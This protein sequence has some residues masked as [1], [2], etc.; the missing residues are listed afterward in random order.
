MATDFFEPFYTEE[1]AMKT[2]VL[3]VT[4]GL[5]LAGSL[6]GQVASVSAD[7]GFTLE[8]RE[9]GHCKLINVDYGR[10]LFNGSCTIEQ[11]TSGSSTI[12][13][14]SM[15]SAEP[16]LFATSDNGRTWMHGPEEVRFEDREHTG[17][18]RWSDFRL[19]VDEY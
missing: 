14:I 3:K 12:F 7:N 2:S 8:G 6:L 17:I 1:I 10:E 11:R 19:E 16:F 18:F 9:R 15:G 5:V 13:T 4:A